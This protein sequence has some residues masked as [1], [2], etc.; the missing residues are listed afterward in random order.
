MTPHRG[1]IALFVEWLWGHGNA[2]C[3]TVCMR[4]IVIVYESEANPLLLDAAGPGEEKRGRTDSSKMW[5]VEQNCRPG[6]QSGDAGHG[7]DQFEAMQ[8]EIGGHAVAFIAVAH[9]LQGVITVIS[10]RLFQPEVGH[11][12]MTESQ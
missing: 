12:S 10:Q 1:V 7:S 3:S 8:P 4:I 5:T 6:E 9:P 2:R 11:H